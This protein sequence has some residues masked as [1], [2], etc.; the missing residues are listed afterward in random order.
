M[1]R[2]RSPLASLPVTHH[3][4]TCPFQ[5]QRQSVLHK[6]VT[7]KWLIKNQ[8]KRV[9]TEAMA[10]FLERR[11]WV[12]LLFYF[13]FLVKGPRFASTHKVFY[14]RVCGEGGRWLIFR[15]CSSSNGWSDITTFV[16]GSVMNTKM[17]WALASEVYLNPN[18][19]PFQKEIH[20]KAGQSPAKIGP[21]LHQQVC[22]D[23]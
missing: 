15:I 12:A 21:R 3:V 17:K 16:S 20:L 10:S 5:S 8:R 4:H 6:I 14:G 13:F 2:R 11:I 9:Q 1:E 7:K 19:P 22:P 23:A 18:L